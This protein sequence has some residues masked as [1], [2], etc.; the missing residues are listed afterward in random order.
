MDLVQR[1]SPEEFYAVR[2]RLQTIGTLADHVQRLDKTLSAYPCAVAEASGGGPER[3][4]SRR[5]DQGSRRGDPDFAPEGAAGRVGLSD[6]S[7]P[8]YQPMHLGGSRYSRD[9]FPREPHS[10][11]MHGSHHH[12]REFGGNHSHHNNTNHSYH[13]NNSPRDHHHS[14]HNH[15]SHHSNSHTRDFGSRSSVQRRMVPAVRPV[16]FNGKDAAGTHGRKLSS[17]LNKLTDRNYGAILTCV[18]QLPIGATEVTER[19]LQQ[20]AIQSG[21]AHLF[22]R[23]LKDYNSESPDKREVPKVPD[24]PKVPE[25]PEAQ[26]VSKVPEVPEAQEVPETRAEVCTRVATEFCD[27]FAQ[28]SRADLNIASAATET[29]DEYSA[30]CAVVKRRAKLVGEC[31]TLLHLVT[32]RFLADWPL[33]RFVGPLLREL[34]RW[35]APDM[36]EQ[37]LE[38][39]IDFSAECVKVAG[40]DLP[41]Q[42][43][44]G[45]HERLLPKITVP[46]LRFKIMEILQRPPMKPSVMTS[47]AKAFS[48]GSS[49]SSGSTRARGTGDNNNNNLTRP[50]HLVTHNGGWGSKSAAHFSS[51]GAN[52]NR[53]F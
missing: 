29:M 42:E 4:A 38:M 32:S 40:Q 26:E 49:G 20:S 33:A 16:I 25:V 50:P 31:R 21:Y 43:W 35:P 34:G 17:S 30:Y 12:P 52:M 2:C 36:V 11:R 27:R 9:A 1:Y 3:G 24:V 48:S 5:N 7:Q 8:R 22:V 37:Q 53:G 51:T 18:R 19:I 15:H 47:V 28:L 45:T 6:F 23:L 13:H 41:H 10:E 44:A 14:H 39:L 46:R